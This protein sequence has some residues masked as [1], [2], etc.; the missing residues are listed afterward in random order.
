MKKIRKGIKD[1]SKLKLKCVKDSGEELKAKRL[2]IRNKDLH[3]HSKPYTELKD[4][5]DKNSLTQEKGRSTKAKYLRSM[6][7][8]Y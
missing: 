5:M 3:V 8:D 1:K 6:T 4:F 7:Q 2:N